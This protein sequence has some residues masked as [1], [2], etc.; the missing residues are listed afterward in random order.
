MQT[1]KRTREKLHGLLGNWEPGWP[2]ALGGSQ[3]GGRL[4]GRPGLAMEAAATA[5][6][7]GWLSSATT[8]KSQTKHALRACMQGLAA[9]LAGW[10]AL[11]S[12]PPHPEHENILWMG[13]SFFHLFFF[14]F[15]TRTSTYYS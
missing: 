10:P 6:L 3:W 9:W 5:V 12:C 15:T 13:P 7:S 1:G 14:S 8:R 11:A 2:P 4:A